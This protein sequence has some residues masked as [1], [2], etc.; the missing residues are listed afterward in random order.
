[1]PHLIQY[2][3]HAIG[4]GPVATCLLTE[5]IA[6]TTIPRFNLKLH[7]RPTH[8]IIGRP[9]MKSP[10]SLKFKPRSLDDAIEIAVPYTS[11]VLGMSFRMLIEVMRNEIPIL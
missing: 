5:A 2:I 7:L 1:M 11:P 4:P 6:S 8:N 9:E 3:E 10:Q